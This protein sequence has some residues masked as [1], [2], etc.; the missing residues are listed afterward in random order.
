MLRHTC[1]PGALGTYFDSD[2]SRIHFLTPV[3]FRREVLLP[4]A[5]EPNRYR[6]SRSRLECLSLWGI[7][8]SFNTAGLV[9][10]YLGDLGERLPS[11]EWG[12]WQSYNVPPEGEMEQGRFRRD[13][14]NQFASSPDIPRDLRKARA[15]AAEVSNRILGSPIWRPLEGD[16]EAE[17]ESM[18]GPLS[19]DTTALGPSLL[20][21]TKALVDAIDPAPLKAFLGDAERN[22]LSL[23]LL[24]RFA[25]R[26]GGDDGVVEPL[27]AL[28][29]FRSRGGVAH[30]AGSGRG[31]AMNRLGIEGMSTLRAFDHVAER[32]AKCLSAVSELMHGIE[33]DGADP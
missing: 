18:V 32:L 6:L 11:D 33:F 23:R 3:Y 28:Q 15:H 19:D 16:V 13:F 17:W 21:L 8:M 26:I 22:E 30:L 9:E 27:R 12:H 2:N 31:Q 10:V 1:D 24:G 7:D 4:Y 5:S 14:L 29:D 20:L 25:E